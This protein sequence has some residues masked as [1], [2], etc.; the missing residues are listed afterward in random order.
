MKRSAGMRLCRKLI[1]DYFPD[2]FECCVLNCD[3]FDFCDSH[4]KRADRKQLKTENRVLRTQQFRGNVIFVETSIRQSASYFLSEILSEKSEKSQFRLNG[5]RAIMQMARNPPL[6]PLIRGAG[7]P[8]NR[9]IG[10]NF[11]KNSC[12]RP[13]SGRFG[14]LTEPAPTRKL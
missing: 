8:P 10:V 6:S 5:E 2:A 9:T 13:K 3:L 4:D 1:V 12:L 14:F 7:P 11:R